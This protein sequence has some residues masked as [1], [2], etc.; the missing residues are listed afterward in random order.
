MSVS[1]LKKGVF[2]LA[3]T[4]L[5]MTSSHA[6]ADKVLNMRQ[7]VTEVS[8]DIYSL[9]MIVLWICVIIGI[10]VFG[11]M[12]YSMIKHRK[13][14]GAVAA[15]F[16]ENHK[17]E[18]LWTV[19]PFVVLIGLAIPATKSLLHLEDTSD[20][21]LTVKVTG[22][23]WKWNY[24]YIDGPAQ[25]V[26]FF[27]NLNSTHNEVRQLDSGKNPVE[28]DNYLLDVDNRL[29]LPVGKKVRFLV[30]SN[31]VIHSWWVPDFAVKKD[32]IPG[33][34]NEIWARADE[35]GT[36]R[37][38]CAEL[39]GKDHGFMP[40]VVDVVSED[41]YT[42]WTSAQKAAAAAEAAAAAS[43]R[44]WSKAELMARGEKVYNTN[45]AAC[46]QANGEGLGPFPAL[47]GSAI[48]TGPAAGHI[49]IVLN[50]KNA[51]PPFAAQMNDLDLAAVITYERNAWGNDAGIVQPKDVKA[52][53]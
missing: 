36:Y 35:E 6:L 46:H 40:I 24:E 19:I 20:A 51:M 13:S 28:I 8:K 37:G 48:A 16:H 11:A 47:K 29:V 26:N 53:R 14:Q 15:T 10:G 1:K 32:A 42:K 30:T 17:L 3:G 50:G 38:Q 52:A 45:C 33:Y 18:I 43:T 4:A 41:E 44:D 12:I 27:S 31:D 7:G 23:Q 49:G 9:H 22:Y 25:G 5:L 39:C 34:I 2:G 21:D